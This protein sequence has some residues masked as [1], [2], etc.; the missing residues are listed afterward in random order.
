M[1]VQQ[2][3][4][5]GGGKGGSQNQ[6]GMGGMPQI[7]QLAPTPNTLVN[8]N[9]QMSQDQNSSAGLAGMTQGLPMQ[10][11]NSMA[12]LGG[13]N[14]APQMNLGGVG[15]G[16]QPQMGQPNSYSNTIGQ[17]TSQMSAMAAPSQGGKGKGA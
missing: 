4:Q 13:M 12:G 9:Q 7:G 1:Q 11:S 16:G 14:Q 5:Q 15:Q 6:F 8:Y 17:Q 2:P 10:Q 3:M